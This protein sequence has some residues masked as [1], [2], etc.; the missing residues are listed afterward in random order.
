[1]KTPTSKQPITKQEL[2]PGLKH[3]LQRVTD[4]ILNE[5]A[6][7]IGSC[8]VM[9]QDQ[10]TA[11]IIQTAMDRQ[12]TADIFGIG[13]LLTLHMYKTQDEDLITYE[14]SQQLKSVFNSSSFL[15]IDVEAIGSNMDEIFDKCDV[16]KPVGLDEEEFR[17]FVSKLDLRLSEAQIEKLFR[18]L[19]LSKDR[20]I[21]IEEF[22]KLMIKISQ[23]S[24]AE[25]E[26]ERHKAR[27]L[28][29]ID[30]YLQ[31][32]DEKFEK[33]GQSAAEVSYRQFL[34]KIEVNSE[35]YY[36]GHK[37]ILRDPYKALKVAQDIVDELIVTKNRSK[38]ASTP[39]GM[40]S[41]GRYIDREFGAVAGELNDFDLNGM[42]SLIEPSAI[43]QG[44]SEQKVKEWT[45]VFWKK[46]VEITQK[47]YEE[48]KKIDPRADPNLSVPTFFATQVESTDVNQ[49][50]LDDCWLITALSIVAHKTEYLR[51][52]VGKTA[53]QIVEDIKEEDV[54]SCHAD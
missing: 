51:G 37:T 26:T 22:K 43:N 38:E 36:N 31:K 46:P 8:K 17:V 9:S 16:R 42:R 1:M 10:L 29:K 49:G 27:L 52:N 44:Y 50:S 6:E 2:L 39:R 5:I 11:S 30:S 48:L 23:P 41:N 53:D 4:N 13:S 54:S 33:K 21:D 25:E 18:Y 3:L 24:E 40:N 34:K 7:D 32:A 35:D 19:D 47:N 45:P 14:M 12:Q 15:K 28:D 20:R